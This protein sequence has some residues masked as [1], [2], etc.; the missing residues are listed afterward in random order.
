LPPAA[1]PER[2]PRAQP[3]A[4][5]EPQA[6]DPVGP[7]GRP[8]RRRARRRV[9]RLRRGRFHHGP[10]AQRVRRPHHGVSAP[11]F[12]AIGHV[13]LDRFGDEVRPGGAALYSAVTAHRLGLS[14]GILTSHAA[15]YPLEAIPSRIEVV[16][17]EAPATTVFEYDAVSGDRQQKLVPT[18]RPLAVRDLPDDWRDAPVARPAAG[19]H[20]V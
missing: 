11:E 20:A 8:R 16:T 17:L 7:P 12:V 19:A 6:R 5:R 2:V 3:Q 18:A 9:P 14:G 10:A 1:L 15:D 4:R 13:T